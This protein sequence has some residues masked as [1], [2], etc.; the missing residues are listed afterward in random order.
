MGKH[1]LDWAHWAPNIWGNYFLK[2]TAPLKIQ[3]YMKFDGHSASLSWC[4]AP[5]GAQDQIFI[6]VI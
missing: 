6:A 3:I 5:S 4:E 1:L 2:I